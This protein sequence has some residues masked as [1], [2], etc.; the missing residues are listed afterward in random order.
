[1]PAPSPRPRAEVVIDLDAIRHNVAILA[2]SAATS[3]ADTMV[4]VKADGYGHGAVDVAAAAL[5]AGAGALGVCSVD[6]AMALR[7]A[8]IGA[9]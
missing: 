2:G 6:E 4:V 5:Q 7:D 8:A 3:G 9:P 1:M